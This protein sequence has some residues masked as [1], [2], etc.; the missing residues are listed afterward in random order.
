MIRLTTRPAQN[1]DLCRKLVPNI[2]PSGDFSGDAQH[3]AL[4]SADID[5]GQSGIHAT[6][7]V[8]GHDFVG[9]FVGLGLVD[10]V[11]MLLS[12]SEIGPGRSDCCATS[13][14]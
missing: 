4:L 9:C 1:R 14:R 7:D 11:H 12:D 13:S 5:A 6:T 3:A 2:T 8:L 10:S